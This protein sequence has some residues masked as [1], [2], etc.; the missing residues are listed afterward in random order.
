MEAEAV[1]ESVSTHSVKY[2]HIIMYL[3]TDQGDAD[4][5]TAWMTNTV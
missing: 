3:F 5:F 4:T 1:P 2:N